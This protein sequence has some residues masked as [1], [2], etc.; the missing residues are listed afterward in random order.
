MGATQALRQRRLPRSILRPVMEQRVRVAQPHNMWST[1][2]QPVLVKTT[3]RGW[4]SNMTKIG[5][6]AMGDHRHRLGARPLGRHQR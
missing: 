1:I 6:T 2:G 3:S 5:Q 4:A